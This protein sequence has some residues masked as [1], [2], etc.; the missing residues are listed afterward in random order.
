[1]HTSK[2]KTPEAIIQSLI[3]NG[4]TPNSSIVSALAGVTIEDKTIQTYLDKIDT[5]EKT[6]TKKS[7]ITDPPDLD[8]YNSPIP[9]NNLV[10]N[11]GGEVVFIQNQTITIPP[12]SES[13]KLVCGRSAVL[14][15]IPLSLL[16][17]N[18][19]VRSQFGTLVMRRA[20]E[21]RFDTDQPFD[22]TRRK[23]RH[24]ASR[25]MVILPA[26]WMVPGLELTFSYTH[27]LF[28]TLTAD[29]I[30]FGPPAEMVL[31]NIRIGMLT[32]PRDEHKFEEQPF[33]MGVDYFQK[34]PIAKLVIAQY[35]AAHFTEVRMPGGELY[36][37][38]SATEGGVYDGDMRQY[39]GKEMVSTGINLANYGIHESPGFS[40]AQPQHY[41]QIVAHT[42]RG[43]Y[44]NGIVDHGLSG[45]GGMC[46]LW[47][48]AG[49][50]FS[51]EVGHNFGLGHHVGGPEGSIHQPG[52]TWGFDLY[53]QRFIGNFWW[54]QPPGDAYF[55][56]FPD[57]RQP[58]F[59]G[60][61]KYNA[62][63]MAGG[64][65]D[66]SI[67]NFTHHTNYV[68]KRIQAFLAEKAVIDPSS[69]SGY[70][71]WNQISKKMEPHSANWPKPIKFGI[72]VFTAVGYY[73]PTGEILP[74]LHILRGNYGHCYPVPNKQT[75]T[76]ANHLEIICATSTIKIP[77]SNVRLGSGT[78][79]KF[80][81]NFSQEELPSRIIFRKGSKDSDI[82]STHEIQSAVA[83]MKPP[84]IIGGDQW[85]EN[86]VPHI[87]DFNQWQPRKKTSSLSQFEEEL[88]LTYGPIHDCSTDHQQNLTPGSIYRHP[89]PTGGKH[90]YFILKKQ[91]Y[92]SA[93]TES[94]DNEYWRFLGEAEKFL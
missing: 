62:D 60:E 1:M 76:S 48:T 78:M 21:S 30:D 43:V 56:E 36:T 15:F 66:G 65:P 18:I 50:E 44:T 53:R 91:E 16:V 49:N 32:P 73:D 9:K 70:S 27:D 38:A 59:A 29:K 86:A 85:E 7:A 81:F 72:P 22:P 23:V 69:P 2:Q 40:E 79:N 52:P 74:S 19:E 24:S 64:A 13:Q 34:V 26:S 58:P 55:P 83:P 51:H 57:F 39:I 68:C 8:F 54:T 94:S 80:H 93:P 3:D 89:H 47:D 90:Q 42:S 46:T 45:G 84:V 10:G 88:V 82:L 67:S 33:L 61:F 25:R 37:T 75:E 6:S 71:K 20:D 14:T 12:Q 4:L 77:L 35:D 17:T 87:P 28:G 11:L 31:Q 92:L 41:M 63:A 5:H